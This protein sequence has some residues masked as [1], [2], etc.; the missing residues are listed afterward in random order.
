MADCLVCVSMSGQSV[1]DIRGENFV[2]VK[3]AKAGITLRA[4]ENI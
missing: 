1:R 3:I 2:L 4:I